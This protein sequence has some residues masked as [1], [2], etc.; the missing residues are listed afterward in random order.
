MK[1]LALLAT[2]A[3]LGLAT[4]TGTDGSNLEKR[5]ACCA[6]RSGDDAVSVPF[7]ALLE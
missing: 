6:Y 3:V 4:P 2:F 7:S 1:L 5:A